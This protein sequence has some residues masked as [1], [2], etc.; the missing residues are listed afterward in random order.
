V[1]FFFFYYLITGKS[2]II[3]KKLKSI[4]IKH[5]IIAIFAFMI[6]FIAIQT[7][8][9]SNLSNISGLL[10]A[11]TNFS[12]KAVSTGH[13][14]PVLYY[15]SVLIPIEIGLI[16]MF[17]FSLF[18]HR[19]NIFSAFVIFWA[20]L[21]LLVFSMISYKT[22]WVLTIFIFPLILSA[23]IAGDYLIKKSRIYS[24]LIAF[25]LIVTLIF[26]IQQNFI[27]ANNFDKNKLGYVETSKDI[28]RI[29]YEIKEYSGNGRILITAEAYW[30]LPF[31]LRDYSLMYIR[32]DKINFTEYKDYDIF[33]IEKSKV[34]ENISEFTIDEFEMRQNY[35]LNVLF[36]NK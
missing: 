35:N 14:K 6:V 8:F 17:L 29:A 2:Q 11:F 22:N 32:I 23:G 21:N 30:P 3:L 20:I 1:L 9:F 5:F 26:S 19:K 7:V 4:K 31:Y 12:S 36:R 13:S 10:D 33:I 27:Y 28:N 15:F 24:I 25:L 16:V 18:F 34:P